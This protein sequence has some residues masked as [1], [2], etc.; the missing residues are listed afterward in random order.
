MPTAAQ[1]VAERSAGSPPPDRS[2]RRH[3][4]RLHDRPAWRPDGWETAGSTP[5]SGRRP[6]VDRH[7]RAR[8]VI[9]CHRSV[10]LQRSTSTHRGTDGSARG[11]RH[12]P[13]HHRL[14][15]DRGRRRT[16]ERRGRAHTPR[17]RTRRL[18]CTSSLR[19][20]RRPTGSCWR[21][22]PVTLVP[23]SRSTD[24][25]LPTSTTDAEIYERGHRRDQQRPQRAELVLVSHA[26]LNQFESNVRWSQRDNFV[27]CPRTARSVTSGWA[28]RA[29]PRRSRRRQTCSSTPISSGSTGSATCARPD[30]RR[31][32]ERRTRRRPR[33]RGQHRPSRLGRR[34]HGGPWPAT[35]PTGQRGAR[36]AARQHGSLGRHP[37]VETASRRAA[38]WRVPVRR[39]AR[40][41][42]AV[43]RAVEGEVRRRL[44]GQL[45]LRP[46]GAA[47]GPCRGGARPVLGRGRPRAARR[48]DRRSSRG[49]LARPR[50]SNHRPA[51]RWRRVGD[52]PGRRASGDR[53]DAGDARRVRPTEPSRPV[54]SARRWCLPALSR[55]GLSTRPT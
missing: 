34:R 46:L 15:R 30:R 32:P 23:G 25:G 36:T 26:G 49:T 53:V 40:P 42:C 48:R 9:R 54:S 14:S 55:F 17:C 8:A 7:E 47:H 5:S 29:T 31:R 10:P 21:R 43:R 28:G 41:R 18:A 13:E 33:R 51:V 12:R 6:V 35:R 52:R 27:G 45:V 16:G 19:T 44:P 37:A 50:R 24:F 11:G 1:I 22:N 4:R 38:R 3:L 2:P 39:L 20:A